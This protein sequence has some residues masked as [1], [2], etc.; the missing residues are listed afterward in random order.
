MNT[1]NDTQKG[2]ELEKNNRPNP[3]LPA[4]SSSSFHMFLLFI[5]VRVRALYGGIIDIYPQ[6]LLAW[7]LDMIHWLR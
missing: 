6:I 1:T 7:Q 3:V 2:K 4:D 5:Y